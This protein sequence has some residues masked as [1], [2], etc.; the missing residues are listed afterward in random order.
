VKILRV[1]IKDVAK[2]ANVSIATVSRVFNNVEP[3]DDETKKLVREVAH[4]MRYTPNAIGRSLSTQRS[5]SIG[6]L[7]PD[8]HGEF[9]SEVIRGADLSAQQNNYHLLVS[10]SH[11]NRTEI[12]A[13]LQMMR[14][15]VDGIIIMSPQID[16]Q[17]LE[18]N[19]PNSL[20]VV[21][22]NCFIEDESYDSFNIDN[23]SGA[24]E[25]VKHL[26]HHGHKR[27]AMIKGPEKNY[28]ARERWRGYNDA[29][30]D[31]STVMDPLLEIHG[32]FSEAS[33]YEAVHE[34]LKHDKK[35]TAI[36]AANDSMAIG[37]L[38]ALR[39]LHISVPNDIALA[40]FDDIPISHYIT[41]TL[42]S[43]HIDISALG[44]MAIEKLVHS[45][46]S[47]NGHQK[48][49]VLIPTTL[50]VRESCGGH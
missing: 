38:S 16:A 46:L 13:A 34:L 12:K 30:R 40:G 32:N 45:I 44:V 14:G 42:S 17:T 22:L 11:N 15:R 1:T 5:D 9:F 47:K 24:Y 31:H 8:L 19:L 48:E 39:D 27:I 35:P 41:P 29:L 3:V 49:R 26:I 43:V 50:I 6:L 20:P 7:L 36:F 23:Y 21:L 28:D 10:S 2:K 33:G 37:A 4:Q 18:E 25:M